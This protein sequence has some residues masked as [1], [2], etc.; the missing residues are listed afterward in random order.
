MRRVIITL[1][2]SLQALFLSSQ[3][4]RHYD[5]MDGLSSIEVTSIC[6]NDNFM[7]IATTDGLNRFDGRN[8]KVYKRENG[9]PNS[10]AGNNIEVLMFDS[11][12]LLWIG[13]KTG[14]VDIYDPMKDQFTHLQNITKGKCP[15]RV[16]SI[17]EDSEK[18]IWL[19]SWEE[20]LYQLTP[21]KN[22]GF[23]ISGYY[24]GYIIS[25][26]LEKPKGY[27][28]F[29]SYFG[30][31]VYD[32]KG[33]QWIEQG[34]GKMAV[35]QFLDSGEK[36]AL[37]CS[38][39][40]SG[41]LKM[42]WKGKKPS[43]VKIETNYTDKR[44]LSIFKILQAAANNLYLGTW[45]EGIKMI[46]TNDQKMQLLSNKYFDASL[47][48]S[49]YRDKHNDIW[50]GT[51]GKGIY[52]FNPDENGI[53]RFPDSHELPVSAMSLTSVENNSILV[54]TQGKGVYLC[55]LSDSSIISKSEDAQSG[56]LNNYILSMYSDRQFIM[57]GHDGYG[58]LYNFKDS[59]AHKE[60]RLKSY[61]ADKQLEKIT[62]FF[63]DDNDGRMWIG[64]KQNGLMS[65][66]PDKQKKNF[67]HYTHYDSFGRDEITGFAP[68]DKHH[69]WISSHSGLYLFNTQTNKIEKD[70]YI[71]SDEIVYSIA[72]NKQTH[73]LWI[74]TSTDL[75]QIDKGSTKTHSV[76]PS[77]ILPKGAIKDLT[78]DS[79]S[80]LW[81][82]IGG[83]IF[84]YMTRQKMIKEIN[85]TIF[86][87][88][89]ILSASRAIIDS[90]EHIVFGSTDYLI[91]I[92][93]HLAL[94]QPDNTKILLTE[95]L[96]DHQRVKAG[97]KVHNKIVLTK[98]TEY[99]SSIELSYKSKW[100]T[101]SFTETGTDF[102][103]NKYQYRIRGFSENW[104][105]LNLSYPISF[106][107]LT[108][109]TYVLEIRE[110]D[111]F[112]DKPVCWSMDITVIP[113]WWNTG[114]FYT[115]LVI[116]I[117]IILGL[118]AYIVLQRYKRQQMR[119]LHKIERLKQEELLREKESF[120]AG[121]SHDL[122][123][124]FSL[125][126]A[127]AN[128]LLREST[129]EDPQREK[130][131][132][133]AKNA[134]F[135]SD[136]FSTILDFKRAE[137]SDSE[138]KERKTEI[139]SFTRL[140]VQSFAYLAK[141][142]QIALFYQPSI[143]ELYLLTDHVKIERILYNLISNSLKY[144]S[145]EGTITVSLE[146]D[147]VQARLHYRIKDNGAG[148]EKINQEKIF[149][150]FYRE[151]KYIRNNISQGFGIGL[152][153]VKRFVA[154]LN[155]ELS[156]AS[157]P[158]EGT[159]IRISLPAA[160][161][162]CEEEKEVE[163]SYK[164]DDANTLLLVEDNEE[165]REYLKSKFTEAHFS[166]ITARNGNEAMKLVT[167]YMP[168]I[169]VSDVMMPEGDGFTLCREIKGNSLYADI[170]VIFLTARASTDDELQGYKAGADIYVKKPFDP[171]ALV[172]QMINISQTRQKRKAQLLGKL[173]SPDSKDI[174]FDPRDQF[175]QQSMKVIEEHLM[176][177]DFKIDEFAAEMNASKTVLHRKFRTL[178]GQTP[179]QFIRTIRLRKAVNLL[180]NTEL[181][182]AEIAYLT[183]F[184][185]SHYF[186]KCFREVYE[187]TPKNFRQKKQEQKNK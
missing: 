153:V 180:N 30:F 90:R 155:G 38:T 165:L 178:V 42:H 170:F 148:I 66:L 106:S 35:T 93:P 120:F 160:I 158:G 173:I 4:F 9:N 169:V 140:I 86:G 141:S 167:E 164:Q 43:G 98:E 20:G 57:V 26:I 118:A 174:D 87:K 29:G 128:D 134:S 61:R 69:L 107:Q 47:I 133:I 72:I 115:L 179:N 82:S 40:N 53:K 104:Q 2:L 16:I 33:K 108:P 144:T 13:L 185:Q 27:L 150:K 21:N 52:R 176:E 76:F 70:G 6:E 1:F 55:K 78:L 77:D 79:E 7:W 41:L 12:G 186:I 177:A 112:T 127:P 163:N 172:N 171:D 157:E 122:L 146:Y 11:K 181:S 24:N 139:V 109:G 123:T 58:F 36:D 71:I 159:E 113:P 183:G 45:G 34:K 14:G 111:G 37:W 32:L 137:L 124:P 44:F 121:L 19:G 17:F 62:S 187:D 168:E 83:R 46:N 95:L 142:K 10:L 175:L 89:T 152:Y 117:A 85:A 110:Y 39:W 51:F 75:L 56:A 105:Y 91:I 138:V 97:E 125:I 184:N 151:P 63:Y 94:N 28:W 88:H 182:I 126:M 50:I 129:K 81:F 49:L 132:I 100:V 156:I 136:I 119:R 99:V 84:C 103:N 67:E 101:L 149:D 154:M 25:S 80:N 130:L 23:D 166:V 147:E 145:V 22:K 114:W 135:L 60:V 18:N 54:G 131:E 68:Y 143:T 74:G 116:F 65:V 59:K 8:F 15:H 102:Y 96:I 73:C 162:S 3:E 161:C 64:S 48:N 92:D 5:T 31:F